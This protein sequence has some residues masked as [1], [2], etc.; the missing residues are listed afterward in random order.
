VGLAAAYA[1]WHVHYLEASGEVTASPLP[2]LFAGVGY[3]M[4]N[5]D[6]HHNGTQKFLLDVT[7]SG[8]Y[9]TVGVR[10]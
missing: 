2:W 5:L 10:F 9:L 6:F 8:L 4:T 7:V 3:K 1:N